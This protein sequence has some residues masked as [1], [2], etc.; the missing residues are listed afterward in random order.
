[1]RRLV[2]RHQS[3]FPQ[4]KLLYKNERRRWT[5]KG[6]VS[7]VHVISLAREPGVVC[8]TCETVPE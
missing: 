2:E 3:I 4:E 5:N 6:R 7:A 8:V 1:M